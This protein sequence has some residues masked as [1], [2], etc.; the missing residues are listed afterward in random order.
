VVVNL[1]KFRRR[2]E[3]SPHNCHPVWRTN[4]VR[5]T[6][7]AD[8]FLDTSH[9]RTPVLHV[10]WVTIRRS[11]GSCGGSCL[12]HD[13]HDTLSLSRH[14]WGSALGHGR[15]LGGLSTAGRAPPRATC[16][17]MVC[18]RSGQAFSP[19]WLCANYERPLPN[20]LLLSADSSI[21]D[22]A[23]V[24]AAASASSRVS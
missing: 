1:P 21:K 18:H 12:I 10:F 15:T 8:R 9:S 13:A 4:R 14:H 16:R 5:R 7:S 19:S 3:V 2:E 17:R 6:D 24:S 11:Y 22:L 23:F 20:E